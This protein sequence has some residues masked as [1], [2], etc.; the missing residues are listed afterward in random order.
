MDCPKCGA[1]D[2]EFW[3]KFVTDGVIDTRR[4]RITGYLCKVC[5]Y[6]V[7]LKEYWGTGPSRKVKKLH[8]EL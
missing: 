3:Q 7:A 4:H 2:M 5:R 1:P 8:K 6:K